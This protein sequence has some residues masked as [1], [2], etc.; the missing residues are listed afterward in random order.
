MT[1]PSTSTDRPRITKFGHACVRL[2][3]GDARIVLDP[4]VFTDPDAVDGAT[5]VLITHEHL[6][7]FHPENLR[8]TEAPIY[9]IAAVA[10]A[11]RAQAP[12]LTDRIT[13]VAPGETFDV[14]VPVTAVGELHNVI[15][16]DL[17]QIFNSGYL[18]T[19]GDTT[20]YHPGDAL[21]APEEPVDVLLAPSSAPWLRSEMAIDFVRAVGAATNLAIHDRIYTEAAHGFL[22]MQMDAL[23]GEHQTYV[24]IADGNDLG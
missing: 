14:G 15:H 9:T 11:I 19:L 18:L 20:V 21:T 10:E 13:V 12:D 6:D 24:R 7:H 4:G 22:Q 5:A 8:A 17:P 16:A 23:I 1:G 3:H 2:E